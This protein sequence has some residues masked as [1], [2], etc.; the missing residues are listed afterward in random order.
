MVFTEQVLSIKYKTWGFSKLNHF[1]D[2]IQFPFTRKIVSILQ[3]ILT[4]FINSLF[5]YVCYGI[6]VISVDK[7]LQR[8]RPFFRRFNQLLHNET[9]MFET[10]LK[11]VDPKDLLS[12][13]IAAPAQTGGGFEGRRRRSK[14][15]SSSTDR[16]Y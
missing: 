13:A 2:F 12:G 10:F 16:Y 11:R 14:S 15:R 6:I 3:F 9:V 7:K 5:C 8:Y 1:V 4:D